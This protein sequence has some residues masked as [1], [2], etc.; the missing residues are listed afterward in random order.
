MLR[1]VARLDQR[2][3]QP[4][5]LVF[6][7]GFG[8]VRLLSALFA[9]A[10]SSYIRLRDGLQV[11]VRDTATVWR[12]IDLPIGDYQVCWNGLTFR[13]VITTTGTRHAMAPWA[14]ATNDQA[15]TPQQ[16]AKRYYHR[17]EIEETFRDWKS[18]LGFRRARLTRW[19]SL[20]VLLSFASVATLLAWETASRKLVTSATVAPQ[21][22]TQLLPKLA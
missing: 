12:I 9:R 11:T 2:A 10:G 17:F 16:I 14:I 7:R 19:Q 4:P 20:Q 1:L 6:D 5:R 18:G 8:N 22:A 13:L 15:A 3:T 21:K